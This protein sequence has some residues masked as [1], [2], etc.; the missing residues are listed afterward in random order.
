MGSFAR[1]GGNVEDVGVGTT[2]MC[3][4][5]LILGFKVVVRVM[6]ILLIVVEVSLDEGDSVVDEDVSGRIDEDEWSSVDG[7]DSGGTSSG[8][9]VAGGNSSEFKTGGDSSN[10]STGDRSLSKYKRE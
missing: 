10:R 2:V 5:T 6:G 9:F 1:G 7:K 4:T 3:G 8:G